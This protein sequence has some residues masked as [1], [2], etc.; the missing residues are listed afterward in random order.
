MGA[1]ASAMS[2]VILG[3]AALVGARAGVIGGVSAAGAART[4]RAAGAGTFAAACA[5]SSRASTTTVRLTVGGALRTVVVHAPARR[6][7]SPARPLALNLHGSGSSPAGEEAFTD[8]DATADAY[9]FVVA[10]PQGAI[11]TSTLGVAGFDWNVPGEPL[12]G[13][14]PVPRGTPD[15]VAFLT[16]LPG[17]LAS[18]Y[19]IDRS[20][21]YVTGF[22]GG[23]RMASALAC[24]ATSEFAAFAMVSGLQYPAR[25][26]SRTAVPIL[27]FHG[28]ADPVDPYDGRGGQR[29][30][31]SGVVDAA[32][33][34]ARHDGCRSTTVS[35][36]EHDATLERDGSCRPPGEV[37]LYTLAGA[38][39]TWPGGP[40]LSRLLRA[41][42]GSASRDVDA[43]ALIWE[44]FATYRLDGGRG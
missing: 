25:C 28:T 27:A 19:C 6:A 4:V 39:H 43:N 12:V 44:F 17:R 38:G 20:R 31:T 24:D 26:P 33:A 8:M 1:T 3:T 36:P 16:A 32:A 9:G 15:D 40:R 42:L 11:H 29:Y 18:R 34:W 23:A 22:S 7:G 37:A 41:Y 5:R 10:Y 35:R 2:A 30:W 13:G 14:T 21:V